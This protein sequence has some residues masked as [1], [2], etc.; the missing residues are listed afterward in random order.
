MDMAVTCFAFLL[1]RLFQDPRNRMKYT[2]MTL[3]FLAVFLG[4]QTLMRYWYYG[5][6]LPNTYY[7]KMTGYPLHYRISSGFYYFLLFTWKLNWVLFLIPFLFV[8][9][10]RHKQSVLLICVICSQLAYSI[11]AGGDAWEGYGGSNRFIALAMPQFFI[12]FSYALLA[13][14]RE[15]KPLRKGWNVALLILSLI[16]FNMFY[17]PG[18]LLEF[19][20]L[21]PPA[22]TGDNRAMVE[23]A[24][25]I[26]QLTSPEATVAV[27]W[28]GALPYFADR[29]TI[30]LLGKNDRHIAR[31]EAR[32]QPGFFQTIFNYQPGHMKYDYGYSLSS[33]PDVVAQLWKNQEEAFPFLEK[34][35]RRVV[36]G[37][38][39]MFLRNGSPHIL[40]NLVAG[41]KQPDAKLN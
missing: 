40:W 37:S 29:H 11:Y 34:A 20:M 3:L 33:N 31:L 24:L 12:L 21:A 7:L 18:T 14:C 36:I 1:Y 28:S 5:E 17:G 27:T 15:F 41:G 39:L 26:K 19:L 25:L 8:A 22:H 6:F 13:F 9:F 2:G 32:R 4:G 10:R 16:L 35:T 38:Y 30:D 23:R